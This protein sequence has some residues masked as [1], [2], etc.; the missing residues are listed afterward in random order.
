MLRS[1]GVYPG[2]A[3]DQAPLLEN[4]QSSL[5]SGLA[6]GQG[7]CSLSPEIPGSKRSLVR[8]LCSGSHLMAVVFQSQSAGPAVHSRFGKWR[9]APESQ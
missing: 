4:Y 7:G 6:Q 1:R 9:T 3:A 2:W 8:S 5:E